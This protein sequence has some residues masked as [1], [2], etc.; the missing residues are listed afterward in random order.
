MQI[1]NLPEAMSVH[2]K[3][4]WENIRD[5][6]QYKRLEGKGGGKGELGLVF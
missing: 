6:G 3:S 1:Q 2:A 5:G 4:C